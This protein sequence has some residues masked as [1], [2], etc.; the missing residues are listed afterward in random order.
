MINYSA[1]T[2]TCIAVPFVIVLSLPASAQ[3]FVFQPTN[4][5][6]TMRTPSPVSRLIDQS[7]LTITY[8]SGTTDLLDYVTMNPQHTNENANKYTSAVAT[9]S[10]TFDLG[11][12]R[13]INRMLFWPTGAGIRRVVAFTL[14]S[15]DDA[16]FG[17]GSETGE[18]VLGSYNPVGEVAP[19]S[20]QSFSFS[21]TAT[22]Y[23]HMD[24]TANGGFS[25]TAFG[26][27]AFGQA[28]PFE[29]DATV[30]FLTLGSLWGINSLMRQLRNA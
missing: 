14:Y 4:A 23:L 16:V 18:T 5:T 17:G 2:G 6:T 11:Q 24:I 9:G 10:I 25:Q 15:D 13:S 12:S 29:V 19:T 1:L 21:E 3:A 20:V 7:G 22:Q 30:G 8:V 26:E 27:V 28:V